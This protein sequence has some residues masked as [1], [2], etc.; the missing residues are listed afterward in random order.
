[1]GYLKLQ[2]FM[3]QYDL[4]CKPIGTN[5]VSTQ[6]FAIPLTKKLTQT[7]TKKIKF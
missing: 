4:S 6:Q 5:R 7:K 1:M 2:C 3:E